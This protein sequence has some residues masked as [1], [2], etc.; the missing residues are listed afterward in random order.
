MLRVVCAEHNV[1]LMIEDIN[2]GPVDLEYGH[3]RGRPSC[4]VSS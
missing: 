3:W 1:G 2:K 4:D